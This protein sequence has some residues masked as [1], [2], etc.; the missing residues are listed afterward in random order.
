[1]IPF[2][3]CNV[4]SKIVGFVGNPNVFSLRLF[5]SSSNQQSFTVS[6]LINSLGFSQQSA[7]SVSKNVNF[8]TC[9]KPDKVIKLFKKYGFTQTQISRLLRG[10]PVLLVANSERNISPKL[11]FFDAKGVSWPLFAKTLSVFPSILARSLDKHIIPS[12]ELFRNLIKSDEIAV[13][14][15]ERYPD[16]LIVNVEKVVA[17]KIDILREH[18][19]PHSNIAKLIL[20]NPQGCVSSSDQFRKTVEEVLEMGFDPKRLKFVRAFLALR[21]LS[22]STW[23]SKVD[24][25]KKWGWS[26]EDFFNAFQSNPFCMRYSKDKIMASM[27]FFI[28]RMG[29]MPYLIAKCP[30]IIGMSLKNRVDPRCSVF[31]V[32]LSKGL[33]KKD[34][35][36][37]VLLIASEEK[38]LRKFVVPYEKQAPELL[39]LYKQKLDL[40]NG[41]LVGKE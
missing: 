21:S 10:K 29:W 26:E 20:R 32:L 28:N 15:V 31:Q 9:E 13:A 7:L 30:T 34:V 4:T 14:V 23:E 16:I 11:E 39:K 24:V 35:S 3:C 18:G 1:M 12:Y 19:V 36:L 17:P 5:S 27:D 6:Y 37:N 38:F 2:G 41:P 33:V 8:D 25:Y 22:K 40:S